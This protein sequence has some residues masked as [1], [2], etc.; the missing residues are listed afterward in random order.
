MR[1]CRS[2]KRDSSLQEC[3]VQV[4]AYEPNLFSLDSLDSFGNLNRKHAR[5]FN[6]HMDMDEENTRLQNESRTQLFADLENIA[7][8]QVP[9]TQ[10]GDRTRLYFIRLPCITPA[11]RV[12]VA[13]V[14]A[15]VVQNFDGAH[16]HERGAVHSVHGDASRHGRSCGHSA[17]QADEVVP[18]RK[19][20][21]H[22]VGLSWG[23]TCSTPRACVAC[24]RC[25]ARALYWVSTH[26]HV[27]AR[28][29]HACRMMTQCCHV[30]RLARVSHRKLRL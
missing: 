14:V 3:L 18:Q 13:R 15:R 5:V 9:R 17:A 26:S 27:H 11:L 30:A 20:A 28:L 16:F 12:H 8:R 19:P 4:M 1:V 23:G 6:N 21:L 7:F 24:T 22:A 10:H 25:H 2:R 29:C